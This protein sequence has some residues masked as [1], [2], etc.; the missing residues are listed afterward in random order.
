MKTAARHWIEPLQIL[1]KISHPEGLR[2]FVQDGLEGGI[3]RAEVAELFGMYFEARLAEAL[4]LGVA[5]G[6][7]E[8]DA[9]YK[10]RLSDILLAPD[11]LFAAGAAGM[12]TLPI[13]AAYHRCFREAVVAIEGAFHRYVEGDYAAGLPVS[14]LL[15]EGY[16]AMLAGNLAR[17]FDRVTVAGAR[18]L[19]GEYVARPTDWL[20]ADPLYSWMLGIERVAHVV[21]HLAGWPGGRREAWAGAARPLTWRTEPYAPASLTRARLAVLELLRREEFTA[22][23]LA[24]VRRN[25]RW[26]GPEL[27]VLLRMPDEDTTPVVLRNAVRS[28]GAVGFRPAVDDLLGL[29]MRVERDDAG[30]D[31][32][33]AGACRDALAEFGPAIK[34][35]LLHHLDLALVDTQRLALAR[36]LAR[37]PGDAEVREVLERLATKTVDPAQRRAAATLAAAYRRPRAPR[38][39]RKAAP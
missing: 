31:E 29:L 27:L 22:A 17:A 32:S 16:E 18:A 34:G 28:L 7:Y 35:Q 36:V 25:R 14:R 12:K 37:M 26:I 11:R 13:D 8:G 1:E 33:L 15:R 9:E 38:R 10:R 5:A 24:R 21:R 20:E 6:A 2:A 3:S 23:E 39:N 19:E 30:A 4:A